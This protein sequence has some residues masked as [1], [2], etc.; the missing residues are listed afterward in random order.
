MQPKEELSVDGA[1]A[2]GKQQ[3]QQQME[4]ACTT[5]RITDSAAA[6]VAVAVAAAAASPY[7]P[8]TTHGIPP[9]LINHPAASPASPTTHSPAQVKNRSGKIA[10][11]T[12][13]SP[14][15]IGPTRLR[16]THARWPQGAQQTLPRAFPWAAW[17]FLAGRIN[18]DL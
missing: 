4:A 8:S 17:P 15:P 3:Q 11:H 13:G 10:P 1:V 16:Y 5:G 14:S 2:A 6:A 9:A 12:H 7:P 18:Q